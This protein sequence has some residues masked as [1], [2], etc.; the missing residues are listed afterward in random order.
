MI[1]MNNYEQLMDI[2]FNKIDGKISNI[3]DL[4]GCVDY[5]FEKTN[6]YKLGVY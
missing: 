2:K 4:R 1:I 5:K 6:L 3:L